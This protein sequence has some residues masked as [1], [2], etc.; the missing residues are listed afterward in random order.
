ML[1][2]LQSEFRKLFT[3]RSTYCVLLIAFALEFLV[4]WLAKGYKINPA[5]ERLALH[6]PHFLA[7]QILVS[8]NVVGLLAA[9]VVVLFVTHEYRYN[10]IMYTL[11]ASKNRNRV[12]FSKL[13]VVSVFSLLFGV[14]FAMLA[15]LLTR[16]GLAAHHIALIHQTFILRSVAWRTLF[17]SWGGAM[18]VAMIALIIRNQVGAF[19]VVFLLPT[20][21]EGLLSQWLN[22][23]SVYLPF[24]SLG[25]LTSP[26]APSNLSFAHAALVGLAWIVGSGIVA[27]AL[28]QT[29]NAN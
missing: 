29:R 5:N 20:V 15:P 17:N 10:T 7:N 11:T 3:V 22:S 23:Y 14:V 18:L 4:F 8:S 28:F 25:V 26:S 1:T 19:A 12:F 6:N 13:I 21:I 27:W 24:S 16:W 2:N 9:I